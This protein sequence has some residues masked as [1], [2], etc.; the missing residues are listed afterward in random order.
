MEKTKA[1]LATIWFDPQ[2]QSVEAAIIHAVAYVDVFD[3]PLTVEQVHR[4]LLAA[5]ASLETVQDV[6][7]N[8][9]LVPD[10]LA[11]DQDHFMLPGRESIVQTRRRRAG[12][13]AEMWPR[14]VRYGRMVASLPFVRMV[15]V[16]GALT[17]DNV[18]PDD[19][20]DYLIVTEPGRLWLS[21]LLVVVLVRWAA[22]RG[23]IVCPNYLL[24]ENALTL[25][26]HNLFVAHEL[27]QMVP[28]SGRSVY[29]RLCRLNDWAARFLPNAYGHARQVDVGSPLPQAARRLAEPLLRTPLGTW[30]ERWE[31]RRK[32]HKLSQTCQGQPEAAYDADWCKGHSEGHGQLVQQAFFERLQ[33]INARGYPYGV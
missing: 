24:S 2:P 25:V 32:V 7:D 10:Y 33:A 19:D 6:L 21:R 31:M 28:L 17:M 15:A 8:G 27:V 1:G 4:Y 5:P 29:Q 3:Y 30:L 26:P 16:T 22:R 13:A 11:R 20:I 23:D 18:E 12:V 9:R 14:A